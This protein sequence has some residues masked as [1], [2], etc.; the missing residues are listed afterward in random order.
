MNLVF[1]GSQRKSLRPSLNCF[2]DDLLAV[3]MYFCCAP[4][5]EAEDRQHKHQPTN[6]Q[7]IQ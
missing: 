5:P 6:F 1:L 2:A 4:Q 3:C 7:K